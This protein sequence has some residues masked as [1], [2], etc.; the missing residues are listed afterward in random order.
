MAS[1]PVAGCYT[2]EVWRRGMYGVTDRKVFGSFGNEEW[3]DILGAMGISAERYQDYLRKAVLGAEVPPLVPEFPEL[4]RL[5]ACDEG[6]VKFAGEGLSRF[7]EDARS[8]QPSLRS[9][10]GAAIIEMLMNAGDH[11]KSVDGELVVHPFG[12]PIPLTI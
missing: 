10:A 2:I 5:A 1:D 11:A 7:L 4:S 12:T 6:N 9:G 3:D 8:I